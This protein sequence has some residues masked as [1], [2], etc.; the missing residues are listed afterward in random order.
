M[1]TDIKKS[2]LYKSPSTLKDTIHAL[3]QFITSERL[4]KMHNVL[5]MRTRHISILLE[6]IYQ[7]HNASAVLR[8]CEAFGIQDV[9]VIPHSNTFTPNQEVS[10][11]SSKWLTINVYANT[12]TKEIYSLL[13]KKGYRIFATAVKKNAKPLDT[14]TIE[15]NPIIIS[16]GSELNGL[17]NEAIEYADEII[18]IPMYGFVESFNISV[19]VAI[20]LSQL[21]PQLKKLHCKTKLSEKEKQEILLT[22]LRADVHRSKEI[23]NTFYKKHSP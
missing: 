1:C 20:V 16:F 14:I 7:P 9:H 15:K 5:A 23:E 3:S 11:G 10:L 6:D 17:S 19:S 12:P 21:V 2:T 8:S 13:R 22:W 18:S 4:E